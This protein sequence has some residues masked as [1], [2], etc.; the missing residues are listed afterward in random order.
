MASC[1]E[2]YPLKF[3]ETDQKNSDG[4]DEINKTKDFDKK[5]ESGILVEMKRESPKLLELNV[6]NLTNATLDD[7]TSEQTSFVKLRISVFEVDYDQNNNE[8]KYVS[9][10]IEPNC[11]V[12]LLSFLCS[13]TVRTTTLLLSVSF[14]AFNVWY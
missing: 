10:E 14:L 2:T 13:W 5:N 6:N 11:W 12:K 1:F 7:P 9:E 3:V 4:G 8:T